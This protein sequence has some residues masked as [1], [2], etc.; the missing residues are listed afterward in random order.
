MSQ[1]ISRFTTL[2]PE[3]DSVGQC[4][5]DLLVPTNERAGKIDALEFVLFRLQIRD[6][7]NIFARPVN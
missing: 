4:H 2:G 3:V 5:Y 7:A 6:L 1:K